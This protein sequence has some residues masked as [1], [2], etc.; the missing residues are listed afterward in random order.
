M[1]TPVKM[2]I[3]GNQYFHPPKKE[4]WLECECCDVLKNSKTKSY[5]DD[6]N[7]KLV[8]SVTRKRATIAV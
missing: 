8:L 2:K 6:K 1:N 5:E 7:I 4:D 3:P